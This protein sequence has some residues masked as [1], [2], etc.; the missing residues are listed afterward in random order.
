MS[1]HFL[2]SSLT[3]TFTHRAALSLAEASDLAYSEHSAVD[4]TVTDW[5]LTLPAKPFDAGETQGFF[6]MDDDLLIL[7][8]RGTEK[9]FRDWL[10]NLRVIRTNHDLGA[11]HRG[12]SSGLNE[13]WELSVKPILEQHGPGRRVWFTGHSLGAALATL[14]AARTQIQ[15]P[16]ISITGIVTFGQPRLAKEEF[17]QNFNAAFDGRFHRYVNNRDIVPRVPPGYRHVGELIHFDEDGEIKELEGSG[18]EAFGWNEDE[19]LTEREFEELLEALEDLPA[20]GSAHDPETLAPDAL[21]EGM[22]PGLGFLNGV[23]DHSIA[24]GYIPALLKN[25]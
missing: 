15:I 24:N 18:Q 7:S 9:K 2:R 25:I 13:V 16:Q 12:F 5:G 20:E 17:E 1:T 4:S 8:F 14:A 22:I 3:T 19:G 23:S 11:V 6:A 21:S 10:R